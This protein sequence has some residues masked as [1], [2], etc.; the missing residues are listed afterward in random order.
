MGLKIEAPL[1]CQAGP[2]AEA[3]V[4]S[5]PSVKNIFRLGSKAQHVK[6]N[7]SLG[8]SSLS[9]QSVPK[10]NYL[11]GWRQCVMT[12]RYLGNFSTYFF[13][14]SIAATYPGLG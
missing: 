11:A 10:R 14:T 2:A 5:L 7:R 4:G 1:V 12:C 13:D 9:F 8:A 3:S 6:L